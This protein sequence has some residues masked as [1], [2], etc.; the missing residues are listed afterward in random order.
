MSVFENNHHETNTNTKIDH[1]IME[2]TTSEMKWNKPAYLS[3]NEH[4]QY[5]LPFSRR[6]LEIDS[7]WLIKQKQQQHQHQQQQ[8]Q[9][10]TMKDQPLR[11]HVEIEIDDDIQYITSIQSLSTSLTRPSSS[12]SITTSQTSLIPSVPRTTTI[13]SR[14]ST[15]NRSLT[16]TTTTNSIINVEPRCENNTSQQSKKK[17]KNIE[18]TEDQVVPQADANT[19]NLA[20]VIE[21]KLDDYYSSASNAPIFRY[22]NNNI[23]NNNGSVNRERISTNAPEP[24]IHLIDDDN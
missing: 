8:L 23:N 13:S 12:A 6:V 22:R 24:D 21:N 5:I 11:T 15:S 20:V 3:L 9:S 2:Q 19:T 1:N 18:M 16:T 7:S 17:K 4:G 10:F 14:P